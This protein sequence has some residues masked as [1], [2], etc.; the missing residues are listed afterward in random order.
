MTDTPEDTAAPPEVTPE[1]RRLAML[2]LWSATLEGLKARLEGED[3]KDLTASFYDTVVGFLRDSGIN[4]DSVAEA[5][6]A[7]ADL[8]MAEL[9]QSVKDVTEDTEDGDAHRHGAPPE[10]ATKDAV[11]VAPLN[12]VFEVKPPRA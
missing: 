5:K 10:K 7:M 1:A 9:V 4:A 2:G 6:E 3:A 11:P 12:R 8:R